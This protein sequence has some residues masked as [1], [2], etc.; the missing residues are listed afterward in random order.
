MFEKKYLDQVRIILNI[1]PLIGKH[2][3]FAIKGGT[4]INFFIFNLPRLSVDI[5]LCY[6]PVEERDGSF[7][8]MNKIMDEI[9][10]SIK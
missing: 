1:L 2:E 3:E 4:A 8:I 5:D 7:T 10:E 6:L 9:S